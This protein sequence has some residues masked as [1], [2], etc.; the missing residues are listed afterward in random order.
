MIVFT[1]IFTLAISTSLDLAIKLS[2]LHHLMYS[3]DFG[4][5]VPKTFLAEKTL[6]DRTF[7]QKVK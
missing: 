5:L 1:L 7:I 6:V 4:E 2:R 3:K